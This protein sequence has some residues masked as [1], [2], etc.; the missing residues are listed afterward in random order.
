MARLSKM[1]EGRSRDEYEKQLST[2]FFC[3]KEISK[4]GCWAGV[5]HIGVCESCSQY[6]G[7]LLI[8]TLY[9]CDDSFRNAEIDKKM[10]L[11]NEI[12]MPRLTKKEGERVKMEKFE[13]IKAL[14]LKYCAEMGIID[15]FDVTM[16]AQECAQKN[17]EYSFY[18]SANI[19]G[20]VDEVKGYIKD[21]SGEEPHTVRFFGIPDFAYCTFRIACVAKIE[22]N[23][24]TFV[25][26]NDKGYF[27]YI[28]NCGYG[29]TI[30]KVY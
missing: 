23:G 16:T 21:I 26:Y 12:I 9:D 22:N 7:D 4:G 30:K 6:L 17:N 24:S 18:N 2:C 20:C 13:N 8:D 5:H 27:D 28:D 11:L 15:F 29:P 19:L 3:S 10:R 1:I 25:L 14:G